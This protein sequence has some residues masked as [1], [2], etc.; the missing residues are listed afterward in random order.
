MKKIIL[1]GN[2]PSAIDSLA[3]KDIDSFDEIVRFNN[4]QTD[5]F[6]SKVGSKT[7]TH[8]VNEGIFYGGIEDRGLPTLIAVPYKKS[9]RP[10]LWEDLNKKFGTMKRFTMIDQPLAMSSVLPEED[11]WLSTGMLSI[12]HYLLDNKEIW[13]Y[14]FDS[15]MHRDGHHYHD[16]EPFCQNHLPGKERAMIAQLIKMR[17]VNTL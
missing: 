13:I 2:G 9:T 14:G 7:T 5:G 3:G 8:A 11:R 17:Q 1:V 10:N 4:F 6:E 16:N 12:M 15:F